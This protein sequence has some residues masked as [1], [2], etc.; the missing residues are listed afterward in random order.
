MSVRQATILVGDVRD[1][2]RTLPAESVQAAVTSP[3]YWGLRDYGVEGQIGLEPTPGAWVA[4]LV[5]V[6][7]EV[8]RV[9]RPDGVCYLN[10]GDCYGSAGGAGEQGAGGQMAD[11]AVTGARITY[12]GGSAGCKPKDLVGQPWRLAFALQADGWWLRSDN[13]WHKP[14][15]M[16]E[17]VSDRPTKA[18]EYVFMLTR[19]AKYFYDSEAARE[20]CTGP[21]SENSPDDHA[22]AF[23][24]RREAS[25]GARQKAVVNADRAEVSSRV[26]K[27]NARTVWTIPSHP[28]PDAHFATFPPALVEK[29]LAP[30]VSERG[31]CPACGAAW[32][33]V[34][35]RVS[36]GK[37]YAVG[38]SAAKNAAGLVTGF[39]G[40]DDG[41]SS[42]EFRTTG[43]RPRCT[44]PPAEPVGCR[45]LD[46]FSGAGTTGLVALRRGCEYV[47]CELN[48]DYAEMSRARIVADAPLLNRV[49]VQ[50]VAARAIA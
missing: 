18:H 11:R 2:L 48:P 50:A 41:S 19:S 16:P 32:E 44:C 28:F 9:L 37:R 10:V 30:S 20:T 33:R 49:T 14:N 6:F 38:K 15:P 27:R 3:P 12:R 43:W 36:T 40:Y 23:S 35:E 8:R 47:G 17:S 34:V 4:A 29:C 13:I 42:P 46:P 39:S 25:P 22:R 7:R 5:E 1:G 24:R 45:V 26:G 31:A 21:A